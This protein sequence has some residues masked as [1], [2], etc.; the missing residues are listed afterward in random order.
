MMDL[1]NRFS[2][3]NIIMIRKDGV[4][5]GLSL[6]PNPITA[7]NIANVRFEANKKG[8]VELIVTDMNGKVVLRQQIQVYEGVNS[9]SINNLT[10]LKPG[11]YLLQVNDGQELQSVKL[12]IA[13]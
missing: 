2:Y 7:G 4:K 5:A 6:S 1:D 9:L 10:R 8:I 11:M 12:S 13:W 3:S